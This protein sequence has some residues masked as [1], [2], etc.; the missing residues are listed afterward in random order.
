MTTIVEVARHAG[1]SVAT[2]SRVLNGN[3]K[4]KP[5]LKQRVLAAVE[6]LHYVPNA[7]ARNLRLNESRAIL[8]LV[9]NVTNPYYARIIA[10]IGEVAH[11]RGYSSFL[12]DTGG[13]SQRERE[14]LKRLEVNQ[15]DGAILMATELGAGWLAPIA[16]RYPVVQSSE[17]DPDV[18]VTHVCIDNYRAARDAMEHL[19]ALGHR[20]IGLISS[21]NRYHSTARRT[22]GYRDALEQ[23]GLSASYIRL[24]SADYSFKSGFTAARSLLSQERRPTALFCISDMLALGAI[25]SAREMGFRVPE[26]VTVVGFDD[27]EQTTMFHPYVTTVVQPCQ[28]I[29]R[30]AMQL[31][32]DLM[33]ARPAP[34][35]VLLPHSLAVRES[36]ALR[37]VDLLDFSAHA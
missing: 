17:F 33:H 26:D 6:A 16:A 12:C 2:V 27:V 4:V 10:G 30:R 13:D 20:R 31:L 9:P 5:E 37:R 28:E 1:V 8:I 18:D 7:A 14:L 34:R 19:L 25:A 29:G 32:D 21:E 22:Q 23:A 3:A 35:E 15:A 24:G 36:S 11:E